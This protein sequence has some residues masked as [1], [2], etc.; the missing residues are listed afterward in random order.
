MITIRQGE[1]FSETVAHKGLDVDEEVNLSRKNPTGP[2]EQYRTVCRTGG[3]FGTIYR[4]N[5]AVPVGAA[6]LNIPSD[7]EKLIVEDT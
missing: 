3:T 2:R 7:S 1:D 6:K 4:R 5:S